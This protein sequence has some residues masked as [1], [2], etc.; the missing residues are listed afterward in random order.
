MI[1][2]QAGA[3]Q[4][5]SPATPLVIALVLAAVA[6]AV[7]AGAAAA[8]TRTTLASSTYNRGW[9]VPSADAIAALDR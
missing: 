2:R 5:T 9:D 1:T 6:G 7:L 4:R 8:D 3:M